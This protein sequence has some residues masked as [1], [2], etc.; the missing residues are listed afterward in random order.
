MTTCGNCIGEQAIKKYV[1]GGSVNLRI[2]ERAVNKIGFDEH[3]REVA[4]TSLTETAMILEARRIHQPD[5]ED[6]KEV[7]RDCGIDL[8]CSCT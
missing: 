7:M 1:K 2:I 6:V 8:I 5:F 3:S 4:W